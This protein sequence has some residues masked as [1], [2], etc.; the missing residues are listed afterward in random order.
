MRALKM[1][2]EL[3]SEYEAVNNILAKNNGIV[4]VNGCVNAQ[5]S[6]MIYG[7]GMNRKNRLIVTFSESDA[8]RIF[9]DFRFYDPQVLLFPAKDLIFYQADL[10]S[11][12]V[13]A[14]RM[15]TIKALLTE[16]GV[17]VVTTVNALMSKMVPIERI[18]DHIKYFD[19][20]DEINLDEV[21]S[22]LTSAGYVRNYQTEGKGDFSVRGGIIDIFPLTE[23]NPV[24]IELWGDE[25]ESIRSIDILSQRSVEDL[26]SI[27]VFPATETVL[28]SQEI[29][30]GLNRL[31]KE[32]ARTSSK[33]KKEF[34]TEEGYRAQKIASDFREEL[35]YM[36]IAGCNPDSFI[37]YFY[38]ETV[39]LLQYFK[40]EDTITFLD[41]PA[42]IKESAKLVEEEFST[43][44]EER[45]KKGYALP[46]QTK[47][48]YSVK[49][50]L[51]ALS[52]RKCVAMSTLP[53]NKGVIRTTETI[54]VVAKSINSYNNSFESLVSDLKRF[55]KNG[56]R[57]IVMSASRTRAVRLAQDIG[58]NG[59]HC[60]YTE[61][62]NR[63]PDEKEVMV[64]YGKLRQGFEYPMI[65]YAVIA[66][67]DIFPERRKKKKTK[68]KY[69]GNHISS[70]TELNMGDY[71][72]HESHGLGIYQGIEQVTVDHVTKDYMKIS[73]RD[74]GNLYIP[75]TALDTIQKYASKNADAKPKLNK[76][77]GTEWAKTT[78]RVR[79]AVDVI[80]TDLVELYAARQSKC[81]FEYGPDT[82]WQTEFEELFPFEET[83]DQ[84]A[85][86]SATKNDMESNKI[87]DRL[88]CGDV[89]YGK[90]EIAIRAAFKAVQENK[91]VV[92]L[93]PTTVLAQQHYT[94]FVQRMKDYPVR[95]D[96]LCR[97]RTPTQQKNTLKNLKNGQV[98][99]VIGTHRVL[100]KDVEYKDLGLL[101]IDEEQR[102]GVTHKE[103]IKK[104]KENVDV[105]TLT[106]TPI[107]RTLHM[108]LIGIRD[109]SV[110][111]EA[112]LDRL[113]IQTFVMEYNE[114]L[115][116][117]AIARE[118]ARG[119]QVFYVYNRVASIADMASAISRLVP[120]AKV[121]YAHGK[122]NE[123]E[124]ERIMYDFVSG[125]IDILVATTI[126]ETGLDIPN[127]NTMIIHDAD[128][129]G[130]SQLYQLRGRVG[131]SSR[132]AYAFL[133][134]KK[135]KMLKEV[136]EK[137]LAAIRDFT[138]LGSGFKIAMRDLEIRGAGNILGE[139]QSGHMDAV[140]YD[141]YC[142]LLNEAVRKK[143]GETVKEEPQASVDINVDA[144]IPDDYI[145]NELQKIDTYK[146]I[147][148][149][150]SRE[151]MDDIKDELTDRFGQLPKA[152]LNL[153]SIAY[154][155][156]LCKSVF[157]TEVKDDGQKNAV[158]MSEYIKFSVAPD[159]S[160]QTEKIPEL[161]KSYGGRLKLMT[162]AKPYFLLK[163]VMPS[164]ATDT[165]V[166]SAAAQD[167][168]LIDCI[169]FAMQLIDIVI[170]RTEHE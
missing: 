138:E 157:I 34:L 81:G 32:A 28:T 147:A 104:L 117:E 77:G 8:T 58:E 60:F 36:G 26:K 22:W 98:D 41:E 49:E 10:K 4:E 40:P 164:P 119:G 64:T 90:T 45:L 114:E 13:T 170:E 91:Q 115:V 155:R 44:M 149:I 161:V 105:L 37:G 21:A 14:E 63:I 25:I 165:M 106:A 56:F 57:V 74:G 2:F 55:T 142:K 132:T 135:D 72:V 107:P 122:M 46:T 23:D 166:S 131:R 163:N 75:A 73:Y 18:G 59:L 69:D 42:R 87:M 66:E 97:F 31:D 62:L 156:V 35:E 167:S 93:V 61:D 9:E 3:L 71:V 94:T 82:V 12:E 126:I 133:M 120:D 154:L 141:M 68:I 146:R 144:F 116:R 43:S 121:A 70:F 150:T 112:P 108:S 162:G 137:R 140:G 110:L 80:A 5:K 30:N 54:S 109:M 84:L 19:V 52:E 100:S 127:V 88:I 86:I 67:G 15:K 143:K 51:N 129:L 16:D 20:G 29:E 85:A 125:D 7:L 151:E 158:G 79:E 27:A 39:S 24:R 139:R 53:L 17:T 130:L 102:F 11:N 76:L 38:D 50:I 118:L 136:A 168:E 152:V 169:S 103:K 48:V 78:S 113:P 124:L 160:F 134:Y 33:F 128:K 159:A 95:I 101:I 148:G 111:E 92:Y 89:G 145:T 1:P 123:S 83:D 65:K 99:I 153:L 6:H 47:L 96:L